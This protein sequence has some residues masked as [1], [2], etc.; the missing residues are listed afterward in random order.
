MR[1]HMLFTIGCCTIYP[2]KIKVYKTVILPVALY[3]WETWYVMLWE[4][5]RIDGVLEQVAWENIWLWEGW[6]D[7]ELEE[8][9]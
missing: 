5:Q 3:V 7:G 6:S 1:A 8:I 4:E 2:L 9:A